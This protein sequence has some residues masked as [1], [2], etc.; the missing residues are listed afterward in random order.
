MAAVLV[1]LYWIMMSIAATKAAWQ[2][3]VTPSFWEKTVHGLTAD[4]P[5]E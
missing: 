2:L 4:Q 3:V 5:S 1:P